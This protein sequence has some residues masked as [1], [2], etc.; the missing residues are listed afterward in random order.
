MTQADKYMYWME[1]ETAMAFDRIKPA[2]CIQMFEGGVHDANYSFADMYDSLMADA[3]HHQQE[4]ATDPAAGLQ[5]V[6]ALGK[7]AHSLVVL[8][9]TAEAHWCEEPIVV[10]SAVDTING[11]ASRLDGAALPGASGMGLRTER[12]W[13][14]FID[15]QLI[16]DGRNPEAS[17]WGP[18]VSQRH[19]LSLVMDEAVTASA[20]FV[21]ASEQFSWIEPGRPSGDAVSW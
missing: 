20:V 9:A 18:G 17:A 12:H 6:Q 11:I 16:Q 10:A 21:A 13:Q 5:F 7:A 4:V 3:G 2:V 15:L 8:R 14:F 1:V 19:F